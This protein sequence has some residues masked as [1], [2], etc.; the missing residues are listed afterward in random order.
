MSH[1]FLGNLFR[2]S[3]PGD[4][5]VHPKN[6]APARVPVPLELRLPSGNEFY[7]DAASLG[8]TI[9]YSS[10]VMYFP[11]LITSSLSIPSRIIPTFSKTRPDE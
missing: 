11:S 8:F 2:G 3:S 6:F 1:D 7:R 9:P 10:T 5:P 4:R